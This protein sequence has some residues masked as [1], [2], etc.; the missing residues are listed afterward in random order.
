V[1]ETE[2]YNAPGSNAGRNPSTPAAI[3][4]A[5]ARALWTT[6]VELAH[7]FAN[8]FTIIV[9]YTGD[10]EARRGA[11][12]ASAKDVSEICEA[13]QRGADLTRQLMNLGVLMRD[14][15][16]S[17]DE[18]AGAPG[19]PSQGSTSSDR[20]GAHGTASPPSQPDTILLVDDEENVREFA[21]RLLA[22]AG[23]TVLAAD[24]SAEALRLAREHSGPVHLLLT[25]VLLPGLGGEALA[26]AVRAVRPGIDVLY[27]SG[28]TLEEAV[29]HSGTDVP[30]EFITKPF[31]GRALLSKIRQMLGAPDVR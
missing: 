10:L 24:S 28:Y 13:A 8:V 7:E 21:R 5:E 2:S 25:D 30:I 23:Y 26:N 1:T 17:P 14:R 3:S 9:G 31:T 20:A 12:G 15:R 16:S 6:L 18:R 4:E 22:G 29:A 11:A 27:M 19:A